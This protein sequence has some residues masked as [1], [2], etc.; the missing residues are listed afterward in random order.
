MGSY[1]EEDAFI[2]RMTNGKRNGAK[3][4]FLKVLSDAE[5]RP[6]PV[7]TF[8]DVNKSRYHRYSRWLTR[9][10]KSLTSR[11]FNLTFKTFLKIF[12]FLCV[13][14]V[15]SRMSATN[16]PA[17]LIPDLYSRCMPYHVISRIF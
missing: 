17:D 2:N 11:K 1:A 15:T 7:R 6:D 5:S 16:V 4:A 8:S 12:M 13:I 3:P 14:G 10:A 9:R